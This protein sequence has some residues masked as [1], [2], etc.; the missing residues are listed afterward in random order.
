M[1]S[2]TQPTLRLIN[3]EPQIDSSKLKQLK[4]VVNRYVDPARLPSN[5][6]RVA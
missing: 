1:Y 6:K 4:Y 2:K 5:V 3:S